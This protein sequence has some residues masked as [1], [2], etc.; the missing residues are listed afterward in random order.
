MVYG[1]EMGMGIQMHMEHYSLSILY[2]SLIYRHLQR[3]CQVSS[4]GTRKEKVSELE[5]EFVVEI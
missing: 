4:V 1:M 3:S 5:L 2:F